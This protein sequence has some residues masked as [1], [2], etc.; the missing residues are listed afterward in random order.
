MTINERFYNIVEKPTNNLDETWFNSYQSL[1]KCGIDNYGTGGLR[2]KLRKRKDDHL[3]YRLLTL[4][5]A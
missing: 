5:D 4:L 1:A 2:M 3:T